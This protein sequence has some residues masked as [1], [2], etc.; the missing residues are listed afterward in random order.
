M[1][2]DYHIFKLLRFLL[3]LI[4]TYG[5]FCDDINFCFSNENFFSSFAVENIGY[6]YFE[7]FEVQYTSKF[8][9]VDF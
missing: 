1:F 7:N 9:R 3:L 6:Y 5:V 8:E 4:S 2:K